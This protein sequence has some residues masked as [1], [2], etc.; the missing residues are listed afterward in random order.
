MTDTELREMLEDARAETAEAKLQVQNLTVRLQTRDTELQNALRLTWMLVKAAGGEI[1]VHHE[2]IA[3]GLH[4][5]IQR[6]DDP[7]KMQ[8]VFRA[9]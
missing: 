6:H 4:G 5:Q 9:K 7:I 3:S 1:V 2:L 8:T